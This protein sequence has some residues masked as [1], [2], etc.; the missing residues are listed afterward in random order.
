[1]T[2]CLL[3]LSYSGA[4]VSARLG[5]IALA[6]TAWNGAAVKSAAYPRAERAALRMADEQEEESERPPRTSVY[7]ILGDEQIANIHDVADALFNVLD[8]NGDGVISEEELACHLLLARYD[9]EAVLKIFGLLDVNSD[10][11]LSRVELREAFIRY[12][13]L[14]DAPGMGSQPSS[15]RNEVH[16]EADEVFAKVDTNGDGLLSL[17]ELSAYL[18]GVEGPSYSPESVAR[19]FQTLDANGDGQ[20]TQSVFRGGFVRYKAIRL[21]L[22]L[23]QPKLGWLQSPG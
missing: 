9:E 15:V 3:A 10:G 1:L 6:R 7:Q 2:A 8:R 13:P 17:E 21:G 19:V 22:G 14:L 5:H 18:A 16:M 20:V 23:R 11:Q 4:A 12:P